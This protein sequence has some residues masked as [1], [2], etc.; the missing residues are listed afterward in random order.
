MAPVPV[1]VFSAFVWFLAVMGTFLIIFWLLELLFFFEGKVEGDDYGPKDIQVRFVTVDSEKVVQNSVEALPDVFDEVHV[2][3]EADIEV[4]DAEVHVV[5]RGFECEA[6]RKG[7]ALEWA[8]RELETD[9]E[10]VMYLDEDSSLK[11]FNGLPDRDII[12][13]REEL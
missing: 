5:P 1:Y 9:R 4:E 8:R 10:Y 2:V 12:Q 3:A 7:R 13:L 11:E 6:E